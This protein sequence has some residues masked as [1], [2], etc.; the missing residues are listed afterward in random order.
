MAGITFC[1]SQGSGGNWEG[2]EGWFFTVGEKCSQ[3]ALTVTSCPRET[4]G[5]RFLVDI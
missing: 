3:L 4:P 2:T 5:Y 1:E